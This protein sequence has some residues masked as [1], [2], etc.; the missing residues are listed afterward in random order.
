M[1]D[2]GEEKFRGTADILRSIHG[3][4]FIVQLN[5]EPM[6]A[7]DLLVLEWTIDVAGAFTG[8]PETGVT[9]TLSQTV[10]ITLMQR[11]QE[12]RYHWR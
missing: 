11:S 10:T 6:I 7:F 4:S 9:T 1:V 5:I 3:V 2:G 8:F 12:D